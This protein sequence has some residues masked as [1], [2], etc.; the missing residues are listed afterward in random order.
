LKVPKPK[1]DMRKLINKA[2]MKPIWPWS[3]PT[4]R[5][6]AAV[7]LLLVF[8]VFVV[9]WSTFGQEILRRGNYG[10]GPEWDCVTNPPGTLSTL[11]CVKK[12][13]QL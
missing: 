5:G 13:S 10:F 9:L 12:S 2:V 3:R 1:D 4:L 6:I 8:A 11:N 7:L